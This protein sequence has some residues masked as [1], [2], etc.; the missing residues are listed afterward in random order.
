MLVNK[1]LASLQVIP[2]FFFFTLS[3]KMG[4][5][6]DGKRNILMGMALALIRRSK[7][8]IANFRD[9]V[10]RFRSTVAQLIVT[11]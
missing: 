5:S 3:K 4:R 2:I 8:F 10:K 1:V 7:F 6:G 11:C 9:E